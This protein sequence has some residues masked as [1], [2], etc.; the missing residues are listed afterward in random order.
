MNI[1][2][3]YK[4]LSSRY[5]YQ[6]TGLPFNSYASQSID[7]V[8]SRIKS[9]LPG[10]LIIDGVSGKG[11]TTLAWHTTEYAQNRFVEPELQYGMGNTDFMK[12]FKLSVING[13][14]VVIYDESGDADKR[15]HYTDL[16]K[17]LLRLFD[18]YRTFKILV[19]LVLP[20][21][22]RLDNDLFDKGLPRLLFHVEN[23]N[24]NYGTV[25]VYGLYRMLHLKKEM[26]KVKTD[27]YLI[28]K[29]QA[30][31]RVRPNYRF[32]FKN[33]PPDREKE[34]DKISTSGKMKEFHELDIA[35]R[36][37]MAYSDIA[38]KLGRSEDWVKRTVAKMKLKE[39]EIFK[40]KKYFS[41]KVYERL[42]NSMI[43]H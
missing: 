30:Y 15:N 29:Q 35:N 1:H 32:R 41:K 5:I 27:K 13:M 6:S 3:Y 37:L 28:S 22:E 38:D 25:A 9:N 19:I 4:S 14:L 10:L 36:G 23:R 20:L 2:Q 31:Q 43:V 12:K 21:F 40:R 26:A 42:K 33:L 11:K 7:K 24:T 16:N 34:L 8:V 18:I 17:A 39:E